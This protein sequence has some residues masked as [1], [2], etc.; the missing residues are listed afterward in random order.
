VLLFL[1]LLAPS[2][3]SAMRFV[4]VVP[5][6]LLLIVLA[7]CGSS[8]PAVAPVHGRITLDGQPMPYTSVVFRAP[9]MSPSGGATD[10][11]GNYELIYRRGVKGAPVGMNH[12]TILQDTQRVPGPQRVPARYNEKSE[13]EREVK[14]GDN[15]INFD[16]TS[17]RK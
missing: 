6:I 12:V 4:K 13:L 8:E 17:D 2:T 14:P 5:N 16:L 11:N 10:E 3:I 15:E 7:G 9:G 1:I